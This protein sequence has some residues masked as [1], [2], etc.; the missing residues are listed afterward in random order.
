MTVKEFCEVIS[1]TARLRIRKDAKDVH[2]GFLGMLKT[3]SV[4]FGSVQ[5][6]EVKRVTADPEIRH[7]QWKQRELM[8]PL[9]PQETPDYSFSDLQLTLYYTIE[10]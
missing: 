9:L 6:M 3:D 8:K 1:D 4:M 7:R 10:I 5:G 2:V